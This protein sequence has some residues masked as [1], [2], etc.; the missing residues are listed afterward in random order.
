[1]R[2]ATS[3]LPGHDAVGGLTKVIEVISLIAAGELVVA[4]VAHVF[5]AGLLVHWWSPFVIVAAALGADL[6]SGLVHWTADTWF[7]ESMP[8]LGRR[9]LR[10]FR[11]HHVN[12]ADFLRRDFVD[13][14]GDV[15]MLNIPILM[16]ALAMPETAL[17][18]ATALAL[19]TFSLISLPTNQVHQWAHMPSPPAV[20]QWLQRHG[21]ILSADAHG[22]HHRAPYVANYCIATGWCNR[23]LTAID[24]FPTCERLITRVVGLHPRFD[25]QSIAERS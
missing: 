16:V 7:S 9:F 18:E 22:R 20:V 5:V 1:M 25:E 13:C 11:V 8:L 21:I 24:F 23:G 10:P 14:N 3:R 4:N 19:A 2:D 17:G 15:A 6:V 12:P